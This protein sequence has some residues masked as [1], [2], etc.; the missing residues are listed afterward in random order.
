MPPALL[1]L[2]PVVASGVGS[3]IKSKQASNAKKTAQAQAK[4]DALAADAQA[5][6]DW[7]EKQNSPAAQAARFKSTFSLGK[8]AGHLGGMDKVP[9][10][11]AAY[12]NSQRAMPTYTAQSSYQ[13]PVKSSGG[14]WNLAAGIADAL[15]QYSPSSFKKAPSAGLPAAT[16][17]GAGST[18]GNEGGPSGSQFDLFKTGQVKNALM[19]IPIKKTQFGPA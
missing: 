3:L 8:L 6:L 15:G 1:A 4:Q 17:F 7:E 9:K 10:S 14:G 12:Y 18:F 13:E 16:G 5:K 11:V 19:D 2:A